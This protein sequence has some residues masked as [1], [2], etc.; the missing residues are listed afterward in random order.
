GVGVS[1]NWVEIL[2]RKMSEGSVNGELI[3]DLSE[4]ATPV[5]AKEFY[6]HLYLEGGFGVI[7]SYGVD[8]VV[9]K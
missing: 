3:V 6:V 8:A 2:A 9:V 1:L 7:Q 5:Q 4:L